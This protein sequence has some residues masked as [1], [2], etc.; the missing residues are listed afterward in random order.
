MYLVS[1]EEMECITNDIIRTWF[2]PGLVDHFI[3]VH[4]INY[5]DAEKVP[6]WRTQWKPERDKYDTAIEYST[7]FLKCSTPTDSQFR[8]IVAVKIAEYLLPYQ[9]RLQPNSNTMKLL[10][11]T[12]VDMGGSKCWIN[13]RKTETI[14]L[15]ATFAITYGTATKKRKVQYKNNQERCHCNQFGKHKSNWN[16]RKQKPKDKR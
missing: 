8:K 13:I 3:D 7:R 15:T 16:N 14:E 9:K 1:N 11:S 10:K 12:L 2:E 4:K 6:H 5:N